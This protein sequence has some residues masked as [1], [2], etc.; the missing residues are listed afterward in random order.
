M[1]EFSK[2]L[3]L[4]L[5]PHGLLG[6]AEGRQSGKHLLLPLQPSLWLRLCQKDSECEGLSG[7]SLFPCPSFLSQCDLEGS[8]RCSVTEDA[9]ISHRILPGL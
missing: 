3:E 9:L 1:L 8:T 2:I 4:F 6:Q 5:E 7:S